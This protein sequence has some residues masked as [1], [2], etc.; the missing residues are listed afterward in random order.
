MHL[1]CAQ[2]DR[3]IEYSEECPS[4]CPYCGTT[5]GPFDPAAQTTPLGRGGG[6]PID[7]DATLLTADLTESDETRSQI[8]GPYRLLRQLGKGGMGTVYEAQELSDPDHRVALK[9]ISPE[10]VSSHDAVERFRREGRL[11]SK[12]SHPRCVFVVGADEDDGQPY[13]VME[14][15]AGNTLQDLVEEEGTLTPRDAV[16]KI[17]DVIEGLEEAH[18]LGLI[19]RDVKP[20]NCFLT[21]E[22]QV[23]IGDF[24]LSRSLVSDAR[25]TQTG[26]FLGTPLYAPPEQ[27]RGEKVDGRSDLY[28]VAATLYFLLVGK[29]PHQGGDAAQVLA[30]IVSAPAPSLRTERRDLSPAL[31]RVVL[32]GLERDAKRRWQ[33]MGEFREALKPFA[34]AELVSADSHLRSNA[35]LLD[36]VVC[37]PLWL[38]M[39]YWVRDSEVS[40]LLELCLYALPRVFY[41]TLLEGI[42][43]VSLGKR[44][45]GLRVTRVDGAYPIGILRAL[46]RHLVFHA[47][48]YCGFY[49]AWAFSLRWSGFVVHLYLAGYLVLLLTM[50]RRTGY[51]GPHEFAS[52]TRV[53]R[54]NRPKKIRQVPTSSIESPPPKVDREKRIPER[55]GSFR[56]LG[57]LHSTE[58]TR[59][60]LA[61]DANLERKVWIRMSHDEVVAQP[62]RE[63]ER[64]T[65]LRWLASGADDDWSWDSFVAPQGVPL[66]ELLAQRKPLSWSE[67]RE[68]LE[69]LSA[70]LLASLEDGTLPDSLTVGQVW[71]EPD[72]KVKLIDT[73]LEDI[74]FA[75]S[76]AQSPDARALFFL[77]QVCHV[78]VEGRRQMT[79][80]LGTWVRAPVPRYAA[81]MIARLGGGEGAYETVKEAHDDLVAARDRLAKVSR[82]LRAE[83]VFAQWV[84]LGLLFAM[85]VVMRRSRAEATGFELHYLSI[86]GVVWAWLTAG[87]A[88]G[89]RG[90]SVMSTRGGPAGRLQCAWRALVVW[91]PY[92]VLLVVLDKIAPED[93]FLPLIAVLGLVS[94]YTVLVLIQPRRSLHDVLA[95]TWVVPT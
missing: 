87:R 94:L 67:V 35:Y 92:T 83:Q 28:S 44:L 49:I 4:F 69:P 20:S 17:L 61:E 42:W 59:L 90:M 63:V 57:I 25:L 62:R 68:L 41:F 64:M 58:T 77:K 52:G 71:V 93:V 21:D 5:L 38:L 88:L 26:T 29:A 30:R 36:S 33:D 89:L 91:A 85:L 31:D 56:T 82:G 8:V 78:A 76:D 81:E 75:A 9:L 65:R 40:H 48:I 80:E 3:D 79:P 72:G 73:R 43:G 60:V 55:V 66:T 1:N 12:L 15:M 50:W 70:E 32:K 16:T 39:D 13:I 46:L 14:L 19:H 74:E 54:E 7:P 53:I 51:R 18:K 95:G 27:I 6:T 84:V 47:I 2:C 37:L 86:Y 23:K 22:G 24:G 11:T 34:T 10:L 45:I